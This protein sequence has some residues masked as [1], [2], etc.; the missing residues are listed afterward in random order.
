[1]NHEGLHDCPC[2]NHEVR[3]NNPH[4]DWKAMKARLLIGEGGLLRSWFG[5]IHYK[6]G[7]NYE[8][9]VERVRAWS[10]NAKYRLIENGLQATMDTAV[11]R[12]NT[13]RSLTRVS[14]RTGEILPELRG[15]PGP[16]KPDPN[17]VHVFLHKKPETGQPTK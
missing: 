10:R 8:R 5:S 6:V 12:M 13:F 1:M 3:K 14:T 15:G 11:R 2:D 9:G 17:R 16:M 7:Q 4:P